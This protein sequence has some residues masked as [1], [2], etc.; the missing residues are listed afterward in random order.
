MSKENKN[1]SFPDKNFLR[2]LANNLQNITESYQN[3]EEKLLMYTGA[4]MNWIGDFITDKNIKW[5]KA[6][7]EIDKLTLTGT[8]PKWNRV[9]IDACGRSPEKFRDFL[10]IPKNRRIFSAARFNKAPI[11]IRIENNQHKVL[12]G[13]KR[14]IA[15]I[16]KDKK[17]INAFVAKSTWRPRPKCEPHIIYD[18]LRAYQRGINKNRK[19]LI[20]ALK[21]LRKSYSNVD[22]LLK[23]RFNK[24]WLPDPKIQKVIKEA[25]GKKIN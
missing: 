2:N 21:F 19:D 11:L 18:F 9:I 7:I 25:L 14:V 8:N 10:K 6:V 24:N 3:P 20:S 16:L 12:D 15:A 22:D 13:M 1:S 4:A 5:K 23:N 17:T